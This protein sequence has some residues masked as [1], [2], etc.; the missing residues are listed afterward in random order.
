MRKYGTAIAQT[1]FSSTN[2]GQIVGSIL[3][4]QVAKADPYDGV[5]AEAPDTWTYLTCRS[6]AI[7]KAWPTIGTFR[8]MTISR[9]AKGTWFGGRAHVHHLDRV[10]A[11][12]RA[13]A[14][15]VF[16]STLNLR[17][18]WFIPLG[19]SVGTDFAG[20]AF[21]DLIA[22]DASGNLW[23]YPT[24]G[25]RGWL[26]AHPDRERLALGPR[27][28]GAGRFLRRRHTRPPQLGPRQPGAD[29]PPRQWLRHDRLEQ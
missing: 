2:G 17:S 10:R 23:N 5:Y 29:P 28:P 6:S 20:N 8:S 18:T 1:E 15:R 3:P 4:Y 14:R 24:N 21:S 22:R 27:N 9:D 19:S 13:S 25:R 26:A 11:A 12:P 16:R 7:E